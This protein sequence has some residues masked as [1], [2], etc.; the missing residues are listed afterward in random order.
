MKYFS[1]IEHLVCRKMNTKGFE[2]RLANKN[3]LAK[4]FLYKK[5]HEREV[6][7][8]PK[9]KKIY[10]YFFFIMVAQNHNKMTQMTYLR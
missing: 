10:I 1:T 4:N 9:K 6:N 2:N 8:F 7:I 5:S 3:I